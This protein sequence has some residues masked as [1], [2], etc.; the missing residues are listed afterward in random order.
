MKV[1]LFGATGMIGQGVLREC[2][3]DE[4]IDSVQT[5]GRSKT[6]AAH[7]KL[8]ETERA[9]LF[10][11][12]DGEF[13]DADA[14]FFCLGVSSAGMG[15][16]AYSRV[17]YDLTMAAAKAFRP[18]AKFIYVSG[19]GTNEQGRQMWARVKGRTERELLESP[20]DAYMLRPGYIQPMHGERSRT[21]L[22]N[23]L[24]VIAKPL[25]PLLRRVAPGQVTTTEA[26]GRAMIRIAFRGYPQK[27]LEPKEINNAAAD[28]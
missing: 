19:V 14:C 20:L 18:G 26:M 23:A 16:A 1:V 13:G 21:G 11:Y 27:V 17:T 4:R 28:T 6:G 9:D 15:E 8:T 22:Y 3:L 10:S 12:A 24:Y 2:L 7:A 5:V 25:Y